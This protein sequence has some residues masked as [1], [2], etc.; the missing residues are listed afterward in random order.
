MRF[1]SGMPYWWVLRPALLKAG[2]IPALQERHFIY[3]AGATLLTMLGGYIINDYFDRHIDAINKPHRVVYGKYVTPGIALLLYAA[4]LGCVHYLAYLTDKQVFTSNRWPL[5][6]FPIVS[7]ALFIYAWQLKCTAILGNFLVS[8]LCGIVPVMLIFA[9]ERPIWLASFRA[10]G[11]I[12]EALR[13]VWLYGLFAFATNLLREQVKDLEDFQGDAACGCAT[14]AVVKGPR[15]AKKPA[16]FT[17]L[18]L[19]ML[20]TALLYFWYQM[21]VPLW[22]M[23]LGVLVL[24]LPSLLTA[25]ALYRATT[26]RDFARAS[27]WVKLMMAAG[28]F[29]LLPGR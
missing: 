24:L 9:E 5:W 7:F 19:S 12:Q 22:R 8:V 3:V 1:V 16:G 25:I 6:L 26:R 10:P 14:L 4:V 20:A 27:L 21:E 23:V 2:A 18:L 11:A 29:L 17:A 13:V 28:L 15:Y